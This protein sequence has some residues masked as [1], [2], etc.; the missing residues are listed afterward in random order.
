MKI[1]YFFHV[2]LVSKISFDSVSYTRH[3]N[4]L[5]ALKHKS[6]Y[7]VAYTKCPPLPELVFV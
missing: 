4:N 6:L 2:V 5:L 7:N 3:I 1:N